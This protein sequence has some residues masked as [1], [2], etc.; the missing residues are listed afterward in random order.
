ME[1]I[2]NSK[3][4]TDDMIVSAKK[5]FEQII[6]QLQELNLSSLQ[7][8]II[9][10]DFGEELISFQRFH[11][12]REGYTNNEFG[13]AFGKVLG[14][15]EFGKLKSAMFLDASIILSIIYNT[16]M[17]QNAIHLIHHEFC[18][19]HDDFF[20][21][22]IFGV[23]D[24]EDLF[25]HTDDKVSQVTYAHADLIWSEYIATRLSTKSKPANHSLYIEDLLKLIP[26]TYDECKKHL[27]E[28]TTKGDDYETF[29]QI[30][31]TCS[32]LLK[33]S[34]YV[35]GYCHG[36]NVDLPKEIN[37]FIS[38]YKYLDGVW[39]C[40]SP[41]LHDM[42]ATYSNWD[43]VSVFSELAQA[44]RKLWENVGISIENSGYQLKV[45]IKQKLGTED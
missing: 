34:A 19:I 22:N 21:Y 29:G 43:G 16:E 14:Y 6:S 20:K 35:I 41:I 31:L 27:E 45:T 15:L 36:S 26:A 7:C 5:V 3:E 33:I 23:E 25:I 8:I 1:I 44:V 30:Q 4:F 9:P 18:H 24:L 32:L 37:D 42:Y 38:N 17:K 2:I 12:L 28:F 11:N 10:E 40:L 13:R 39:D